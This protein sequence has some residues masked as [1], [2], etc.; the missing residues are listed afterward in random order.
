MG[1]AADIVLI[2]CAALIGGLIA[3]RLG[4]P[5]LVGYIVA[6]VLVGP[7]T[8]GPTVV[9]IHEIELLA[10]I[11]VALLL[12]AL[13]M[14]VSFKDLAPVRKIALIG[15]PIQIVLSI[16]LGYAIGSG[17]LGWGGIES[18]WFGAMIALSSTMVTLKILLAQGTANTLASRVMIG[19]LIVQDLAVAP[20]LIVLPKLNDLEKALP[21]LGLAAL[22]AV[23]F[24]AAMIFVGTRLIPWALKKIVHWRDHELFLVAVLALGVGVGYGTYL[25]G[26]S[27]AFGAFV[28]GMVLSESELSHQALA[29]IVPLRDIFGLL[30]F[31]SAG[32]LFDPMFL[33]ENFGEVALTVALVIVGKAVIFGL[34]TRWFGYGNR[35]P[36]IVGLGLAQIGEFAFVLAR[37]GVSTQS[38]SQEVYS[39]ALTATLATM[40]LSPALAGLSGPLYARWRRLVP[41][42]EPLQTFHL[43]EQGLADHVIVAG[44][45]R[46]GRAAVQVMG[47]IGVPYLVVDF[48]HE[49]IAECL[50]NGLP[51]IWGDATRPQTLE[52]AGVGRARLL[53]LT[54]P[55]AE[56][57]KMVVVKA[58]E[59]QP[60]IEVVAR[61]LYAEHMQELREIGVWSAV[62]PE[63]EAGLA[64]VRQVLTRYNAPA[65]RIYAFSEAVRQEM[66]APMSGEALPPACATV[67][68]TIGRAHPALEI[69][70][71][72]V[73]VGTPGVGRTIGELDLRRETGASIVALVRDGV[74]LPN[75]GPEVALLPGDLAALLGA[76]NERD[77]ARRLLAGGV[78]A[79]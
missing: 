13:G 71:A 27:F 8:A 25:F 31:A 66:Y 50:R 23:G 58:R 59:A 3:Q 1:I 10:E 77:E 37:M 2:V 11:G 60:G 34:L 14:E 35:A 76:P 42:D 79:S 63:F 21:A 53:F 49:N 51:A 6:G 7:N 75:P 68:D 61:A 62:Q 29:D 43:P 47:R 38:I 4:Q 16:L 12:F 45:G 78:S 24:L 36:F 70:W 40:V 74:A 30:F 57:M 26:L 46:T 55:D 15:G 9:E 56:T 33:V 17:V 44:Y 52:A 18:V 41:Q 73:C 39:L 48:D 54:I 65:E 32:M 69:G 64:M 67:L 28:A 72:E 5:L 19:L 20:L 22:Q